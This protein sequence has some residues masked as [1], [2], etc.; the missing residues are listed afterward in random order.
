VEVATSRVLDA[1]VRVPWE[2]GLA[3]PENMAEE[4]AWRAGEGKKGRAS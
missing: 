4:R 1:A 3:L 2:G